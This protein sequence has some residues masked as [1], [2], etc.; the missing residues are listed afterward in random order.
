MEQYYLV[1]VP[2]MSVLALN[3]GLKYSEGYGY[4]TLIVLII[5]VFPY[6]THMRI[7]ILRKLGANPIKSQVK[8]LVVCSTINPNGSTAG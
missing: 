6:F 5:T 4:D 3:L 2:Y 8:I 1:M 7:D